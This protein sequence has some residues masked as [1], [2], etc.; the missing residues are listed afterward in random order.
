MPFLPDVS[1]PTGSILVAVN[2]RSSGWKALD[3]AAAESAARRS[4]L[5]ILH[6]VKPPPTFDALVAIPPVWTALPAAA[7][8][9][10]AARVLREAVERARRIA[11]GALVTAHLAFGSPATV[12]RDAGGADSLTVVGRGRA[13]RLARH[14]TS[15]RIARR[16]LGHVAI[17]EL[18]DQPRAGPS[19]GRVVL[20]FEHATDPAPAVAHAFHA[21]SR[22]GIGLTVVYACNG[23][24]EPPHGRLPSRRGLRRL[25]GIAT[26]EDVVH[27]FQ[28]A[29]PDVDV[30]RRLT[31]GSAAAALAG[32]SPAAAL[33]V[34]G[35]GAEPGRR[36]TT[37]GSLARAAAR[38]ARSP[39]AI[40]RTAA[41]AARVSGR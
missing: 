16:A 22:R 4:P 29:F 11:P 30:R 2:G 27:C 28:R 21:A 12:I 32:E 35:T 37:P 31:A 17:V 13:N 26:I 20:G 33:L 39:I 25:H 41:P 14:S 40:I 24:A 10:D 38:R 34:I 19:A 36:H 15:W 8:P 18:D 7:A 9:R 1:P 6:V 3:W 23:F 5:R